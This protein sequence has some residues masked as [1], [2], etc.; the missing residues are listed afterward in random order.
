VISDPTIDPN[1]HPAVSEP[2]AVEHGISDFLFE[3]AIQKRKAMLA[4]MAL[5]LEDV[6]RVTK[7]GR[8]IEARLQTAAR[9]AVEESLAVWKVEMDQLAHSNTPS[10]NSRNI[11]QLLNGLENYQGSNSSRQKPEERAVWK[12]AIRSELTFEQRNQWR[13]EVEA[14]NGY[15][16]LAISSSV[17]AGFDEKVSLSTKQW[18]LLQP[19]VARVIREYR[20][21]IGRLFGFPGGAPWYLQTI[22]KLIPLAGIPETKLKEILTAEQW[23]RWTTSG[24]FG[25]NTNYWLMI[26]QNHQARED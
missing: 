6:M 18:S 2:E 11:R 20:P 4:E 3:K 22:S 16:D 14:R 5:K 13:G 25:N 23:E 26:E 7:A 17:L 15:R 1:A 12:K 8:E 21:D 10:A 24:E 19:L 9:G